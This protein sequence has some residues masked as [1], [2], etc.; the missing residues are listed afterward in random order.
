ML[1]GNLVKLTPILPTD[2]GVLFGWADD[3]EAAR[4]NEAYRPPVWK[5]QEDLWF[6]RAQDPTRVFF[7][8]RR[9]EEAGLVGYVQ[10]W[11]ID[12]VHRSA[13]IGL[14][15]GEAAERGK[16]YGGEALRLALDFCWNHL[17]LS[18]IALNVFA[19]NAAA[20]RLY[21]AQGFE[22]EGVCRRAQFIDGRWVDLVLMA[23]LHPSR[24]G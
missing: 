18:R 16:G 1:V 15:V 11:N 7:A 3:L 6:N 12:A 23:R 19:D 2:F 24:E 17:N 9:R 13:T 14:R 21:T 4:L 10:I 8:L 5:G 20:I 22:T